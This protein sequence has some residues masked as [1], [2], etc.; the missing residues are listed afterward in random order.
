M[1]AQHDAG[2]LVTIN[3]D[4]RL[5][6]GVTLTDE[7]TRCATHLGFDLPTLAELSLAAFDASFLAFPERRAAARAR[8]DR[9]RGVAR[10]ATDSLGH[11]DAGAV[12][13]GAGA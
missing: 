5:M 7:Y 9:H 3:T 11:H 2:V 12:V 1:R 4:N 10:E 8:G 6:S 13:Q